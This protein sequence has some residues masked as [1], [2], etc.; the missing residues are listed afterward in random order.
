MIFNINLLSFVK[1]HVHYQYWFSKKVD[2][3]S[4]TK[5]NKSHDKIER[6][7][8]IKSL[9]D[10]GLITEEEFENKKKQILGS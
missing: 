6:L 1:H 8:K 7:T 5:Q 3:L 9:L 4:N 2:I 10:K